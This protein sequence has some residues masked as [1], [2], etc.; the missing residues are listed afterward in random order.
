[1]PSLKRQLPIRHHFAQ[2][3]RPL[4]NERDISTGANEPSTKGEDVSP[5]N[6]CSRSGSFPLGVALYDVGRF[7]LAPLRHWIV[8]WQWLRAAYLLWP[9]FTRH[10][11]GHL[12]LWLARPK[13]L[14]CRREAD[15]FFRTP[16]YA[17]GTCHLRD[18]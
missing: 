7:L 5:Y 11:P 17:P 4:A 3:H 2:L 18:L 8:W 9:R 14:P 15:H 1:M 6:A 12:H 10:L 16:G 13:A